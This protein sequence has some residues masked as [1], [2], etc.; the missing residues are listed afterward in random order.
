MQSNYRP[1]K[2]I[3]ML[4][5][6]LV[7]HVNAAAQMAPNLLANAI[8][9]QAEL[10][11]SQHLNNRNQAELVLLD[12]GVQPSFQNQMWFDTEIKVK[13]GSALRRT[14]RESYIEFLSFNVLN[15]R[16]VTTSY[17]VHC[18]E[19]CS[20]YVHVYEFEYDASGN[21]WQITSNTSFYNRI[22]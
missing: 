9:T 22:D 6:L 11:P 10:M 12:N 19:G 15:E 4:V 3:G 7:I 13:T 2:L 20:K 1:F 8:F 16:K 14:G 17:K 21:V 18:A 5:M